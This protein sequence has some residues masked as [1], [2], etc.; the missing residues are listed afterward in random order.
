MQ[1]TTRVDACGDQILDQL[2]L[3]VDGRV[4]TGVWMKVQ[5]MGDV[6]VAQVEPA[7]PHAFAE[8]S[9]TQTRRHE[10]IDTRLLDDARPQ[11][12]FDVGATAALQDDRVDAL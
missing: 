11:A 12:L 9:V 2:V 1:R 4:L 3:A 8:Q 6:V 7:V 5:V 10:Q